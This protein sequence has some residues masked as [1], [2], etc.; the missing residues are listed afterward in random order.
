MRCVVNLSGAPLALDPGATVLLAS[1]AI[2]DGVL[3]HDAAAW[4]LS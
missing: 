1:G 4:L 2:A 3:P